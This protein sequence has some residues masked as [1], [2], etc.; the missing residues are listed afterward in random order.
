[1][2]CNATKA[3]YGKADLYRSAAG[4]AIPSVVLLAESRLLAYDVIAF[5]EARGVALKINE[6]SQ[7]STELQTSG[8][9]AWGIG[10]I[11]NRILPGI[12]SYR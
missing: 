1:M 12:R 6:C 2:A 4:P 5:A 9:M 7:E 8:R 10:Y 3:Y 11:Q